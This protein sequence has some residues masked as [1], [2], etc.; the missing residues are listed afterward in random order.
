MLQIGKAQEGSFPESADTSCQ[1]ETGELENEISRLQQL[2]HAAEASNV[3]MHERVASHE[4]LQSE[5]ASLIGLLQQQQ[6]EEE[7]QHE[8]QQ[9]Q[10]HEVPS[11]NQRTR[12]PSFAEIVASVDSAL[13][14]FTNKSKPPS[15]FAPNSVASTQLDAAQV[16]SSPSR[17]PDNSRDEELRD[18]IQ[19]RQ[20]YVER[21]ASYCMSVCFVCTT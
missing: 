12:R 10:S 8:K 2:L 9:Q 15:P 1:T 17:T 21:S 11:S 20:K 14:T 3:K 7:G 4:E 16:V 6:Q 19:S 5:N 18:C 13:L